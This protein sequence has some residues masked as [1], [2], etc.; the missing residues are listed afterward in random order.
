MKF[1]TGDNVKIISG[2]DRGKEGKILRT[3]PLL[4]KIEVDGVNVKKKH[5][6]PKKQG[7]KGERIE[8]SAPFF[9]SR[10]QIVCGSCG[11]ITR[12]G[13]KIDGEKKVRVCKK[14]GKEL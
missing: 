4:G 3:F 1:R 2:N 5:T 8:K 14:C 9:A 7:Q 11:A 10:A 13:Y 6:K 12:I